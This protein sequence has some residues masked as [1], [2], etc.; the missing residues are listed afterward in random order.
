MAQL[1]RHQDGDAQPS[2]SGAPETGTAGGLL[3]VERISH[4]FGST[5]ALSDVSL[6]VAPGEIHGLCG[7]NGAGKSTL[8]KIISGQ[9]RPD[10]GVIRFDGREVRFTRPRDAQECGVA[11]VDQ[12]LSVVPALSVEE[13]VLLGDVREGFV[14]RRRRSRPRVRELLA[15]VGLGDLPLQAPVE[16]LSMAER[17]LLEIARLL[18]RDARL[19]ILDEPTA[20]LSRGDSLLVFGALR[21][22]AAQGQS[23]LYVSHRL[24]EV[25]D[26]CHRVT[27]V[28]DGR[29]IADQPVR[30]LDHGALVALIVGEQHALEMSAEAVRATVGEG[31]SGAAGDID[32][33]HLH[34][35]ER[36][37]DVSLRLRPGEIVALAGQVGSGASE[38]LRA[39]AG[40][41]RDATGQVRVGGRTVRLGSPA[42][43][44]RHGIHFVSNDRKS[45][46]LFLS[47]SV[48]HNLLATRLASV[49]RRGILWRGELRHRA[50]ALVEHVEL[51]APG[52][53]IPVAELSGGN[54]QKVFIGRSLGHEASHLLLLDEPTR[55]VDV[56]GRADIHNL[57]RRAAAEG[58]AVLFA[59]G[60]PD[61]VL[62]L[63]DR[64]VCMQQGE[65]VSVHPAGE[66]TEELLLART[67]R[68]REAPHV[69]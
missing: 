60:E 22:L 28:R 43:A 37:N 9:L 31:G 59:S 67:T 41:E 65:I 34:V 7:Q 12:E 44:A 21:E 53:S 47:R 42:R 13:N 18:G 16:G 5:Q 24:D 19:L 58:A 17:Q 66:M 55:G 40:L 68:T 46:G 61:E 63:A 33:A 30:E 1:S 23:V 15:R 69:G 3:E 57:V 6:Q 39:L 14:A 2:P 25:L 49:G 48:E 20:S 29:R 38:V 51:Q 10:S 8:V 27:V 35:G 36:V 45:E 11:V 26:L 52:L 56:R 32:V 50:E 62:E 54:Q 4:A 64:I